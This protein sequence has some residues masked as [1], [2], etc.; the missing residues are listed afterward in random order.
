MANKTIQFLGQGYGAT[1]CT[2]T[3]YF[4]GAEVFSGA[5]PTVDSTDIGRLPEDQQVVFSF[6]VPM[7]T[8]GS[9]PM[10]LAISGTDTYLEQVLVNYYPVQNPVYTQ[11]EITNLTTIGYPQADKVT[12][13]E[14]HAVPPLSAEDI[15]LLSST[16]P[17]DVPAQMACLAAHNLTILVSSGPDAYTPVNAGGDARSNVVVTGATY[18]SPPPPDPRAPDSEGTWGWEIETAPGTTAGMTYQLNLTS[19]A[20]A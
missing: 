18:V 13:Y 6:E 8:T 17:D 14:A 9:I 7:D 19:A 4:N 5:I 15:T 20:L 1:P 12:I 11:E 3:A 16:N 2:I 10:T